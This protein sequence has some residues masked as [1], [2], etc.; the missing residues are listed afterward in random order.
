LQFSRSETSFIH[1]SPMVY[2]RRYRWVADLDLE[3]FPLLL[4]RLGTLATEILRP[5]M[6]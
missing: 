4:S 3:K 2:R 5:V 6:E 1:C